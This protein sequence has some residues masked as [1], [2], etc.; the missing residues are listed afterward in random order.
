MTDHFGEMRSLF[1]QA[2]TWT[3]PEQ[4]TL[5]WRQLCFWIEQMGFARFVDRYIVHVQQ[6]LQAWPDEVRQLPTHW[7]QHALLNQ[8]PSLMSLARVMYWPVFDAPIEQTKTIKQWKLGMDLGHGPWHDDLFLPPMRLNEDIIQLD[9]VDD[10]RAIQRSVLSQFEQVESLTHLAMH[11]LIESST[12]IEADLP[13]S[14]LQHL[15]VSYNALDDVFADWLSHQH[16]PALNALWVADNTLT[17][18]GVDALMDAP[19]CTQLASLHLGYHDFGDALI[20]RLIAATWPNLKH[21]HLRAC[22]LRATGARW[23]AN[24]ELTSQLHTLD[25]LNN[26]LELDGV[27]ALLASPALSALRTLQ[28]GRTHGGAEAVSVIEGVS[29][30]QHLRALGLRSNALVTTAPACSPGHRCRAWSNWIYPII[31]SA[32]MG[33][34][35]SWTLNG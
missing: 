33:C 31:A 20:S 4:W 22:G 8:Y 12:L 3:R 26:N 35:R 28:L 23:L 2:T 6:H 14:A 11:M 10:L 16:M 13:I 30:F 9:T 32:S 15:D 29:H 18:Q 7:Q 17:L 25:L 24:H 19:W 27:A 5:G 34:S 21:L 1:Q